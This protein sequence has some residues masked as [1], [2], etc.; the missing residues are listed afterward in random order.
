MLWDLVCTVIPEIKNN[1]VGL[2]EAIFSPMED[3][4]KNKRGLILIFK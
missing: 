1:G 4:T 3:S 2:V